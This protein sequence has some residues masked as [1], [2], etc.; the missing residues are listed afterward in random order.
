MYGLKHD[1]ELD[2]QASATSSLDDYVGNVAALVSRLWR[3]RECSAPMQRLARD[4]QLPPEKIVDRVG[5]RLLEPLPALHE[6][7]RLPRPARSCAARGRAASRS[8]RPDLHV[9][10]VTGDGDC[11][12]IGTAHWIHAIRYNMNMTVM[13]FDNNIYGLTKMQSVA[14]LAQ[15]GL[16]T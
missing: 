15:V 9:F 16:A 1:W 6:D 3:P 12:A 7:L 5:H 14:D 2:P 13:L 10:V 4:E 8:R 11:C